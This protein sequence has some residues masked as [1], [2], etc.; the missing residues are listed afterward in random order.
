MERE[1]YVEREDMERKMERG[2]WR[3]RGYAERDGEREMERGIWRERERIW[4]ERRYAER[5][6][7]R[8]M[9]RDMVREAYGERE[10]MESR[11]IMDYTLEQWVKKVFYRFN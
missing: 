8:D 5:D 1:G 10:D 4:R 3:E 7:E 6:R 11:D 2:I 9:E